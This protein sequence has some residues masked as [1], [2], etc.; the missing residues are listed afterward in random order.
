MEEVRSLELAI[1]AV[2]HLVVYSDKF[3]VFSLQTIKDRTLCF[4]T[5]KEAVGLI[6]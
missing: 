5:K 1:K 3:T 6:L 2:F 4:S